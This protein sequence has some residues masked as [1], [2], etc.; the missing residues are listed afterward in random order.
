VYFYC[1][2]R[3]IAKEI[4]TRDVGYFVSAEAGVPHPNI[5][6]C[7]ALVRLEGAGERYAMDQQ[8]ERN[9]FWASCFSK[10]ATNFDRAD[11]TF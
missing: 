4:K 6:L 10:S 2:N 1:N 9:Q 11:E 3:L 5:S 7:R 8:Q